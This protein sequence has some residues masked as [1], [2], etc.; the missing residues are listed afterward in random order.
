[1]YGSGSGSGAGAGAAATGSGSTVGSTVGSGSGAGAAAGAAAA[2]VLGR[3]AGSPSPPVTNSIVTGEP[4]A[5]ASA[6]STAARCSPHLP[7]CA[8]LG[9]LNRHVPPPTSPTNDPAE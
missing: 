5:S 6:A 3:A 9:T 1:M 4:V 8:S 7:A 2:G